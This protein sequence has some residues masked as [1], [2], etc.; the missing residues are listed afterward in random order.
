MGPSS[1][2]EEG[3]HASGGGEE[4][5]Q[6]AS[7]KTSHKRAVQRCD[8]FRSHPVQSPF[9]TRSNPVR[10]SRS[11]NAVLSP[12]PMAVFNSVS[13]STV[14]YAKSEYRQSVKSVT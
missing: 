3:I 7:K 10:F 8:R 6:Y 4:G 2:G 5:I 13:N 11:Y 14:P 1:N 12:V 9:E